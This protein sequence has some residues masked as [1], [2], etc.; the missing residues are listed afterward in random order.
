MKHEIDAEPGSE[1][2]RREFLEIRNGFLAKLDEHLK[3]RTWRLGAVDRQ[4]VVKQWE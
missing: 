4:L 1:E 3:V 2:F